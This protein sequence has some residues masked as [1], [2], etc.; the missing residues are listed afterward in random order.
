M[1]TNSE[2][3]RDFKDIYDTYYQGWSDWLLEAQTDLEMYLGAQFT[4]QEH[5]WAQNEGRTL[6]VFNK[7]KRQVKLLHGYEI[8]NRHILKIGPIG[9]EDDLACRQHTG[10]VMNI[11]SGAEGYDVLS[12]A[13]RW[14]PLVTGSNLVEIWRDRNG[15]LK[16]NRIGHNGFLLDPMLTKPDLSDCAGILTGNW[17]RADKVKMLLPENGDEIDRIHPVKSTGR[18]QTITGFPHTLQNDLRLYEQ[19]W[20]KEIKYQTMV[21]DRITGKEIPFDDFVNQ[22][23]RGDRRRANWFIKNWRL[24]NGV[25]GLSKFEKPVNHVTLD[26][27]VDEQPVWS[28]ENP[29][30]L[31]DYNFIWLPGDW[32]PECDR[33]ELKLQGFARSIREPQ[34]ARNRRLN[35]IIDIIETQLNQWRLARQGSLVNKEDAYG[36]GQGK[37]VWIKKDAQGPL[38]EHFEQ[39]PPP[40]IPGGLFNVLEVLD[41]EE[42]QEGGLNEEIMGSDDKEIPGILHRYRTGAALTSQQGIFSGYRRAKRQLG[43]KIVRLE[44]LNYNPQKIHRLINEWPSPDFY[45]PDFIKYDCT[46]TEGLLTDSQRHLWYLELKGLR[47][48]F[49]DAQAVI[50]LS[51][52]IQAAPIQYKQELLQAV[53]QAE[54][55]QKQMMQLQLADKQRM[56]RL[57]EAQTAED[58]AQAAENRSGALLD[59]VKAM[60]EIRKMGVDSILDIL[61]RLSNIEQTLGI[62]GREPSGLRK[63]KKRIK[64]A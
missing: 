31:D 21:I 51:F 49:P 30:G 5:A 27:F 62:G 26:I 41:R 63:A 28:G 57:L 61:E 47:A 25:P 42:T 13:F 34:K 10:V 60:A 39:Q 45:Q 11:M 14:G 59:R 20:R 50:P 2:L 38:R 22:V 9:R 7:I 19:W 18:W 12:E 33:D 32:V 1:A 48:M 17:L 4:R 35:Q 8:R 6:F 43:C 23:M 54:Q 29:L 16:F 52:I 24:P 53:Q 44:Q 58:I 15:D 36:S 56:D 46:P 37:V 40:E 64:G 3:R 55:T